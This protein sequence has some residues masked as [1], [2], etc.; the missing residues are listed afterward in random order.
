M[1]PNGD[2]VRETLC[3]SSA[4]VDAVRKA[5]PPDAAPLSA[6]LHFLQGGFALSQHGDATN[7]LQ[8]GSGTSVAKQVSH[9]THP[10]LE[11]LQHELRAMGQELVQIGRPLGLARA[12]EQVEGAEWEVP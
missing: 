12:G 10:L 11:M 8:L 6:Y 3:L 5:R 4:V 7:L 1:R 9:L 2:K